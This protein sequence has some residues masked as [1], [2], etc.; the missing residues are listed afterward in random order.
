M[1]R[2]LDPKI[3]EYPREDGTTSYRVRVRTGGKQSTETFESRSAAAVFVERIKDP[4]VGPERAVALRSREDRASNDY[5]PTLTEML[6]RHIEG[7]TGVEGATKDEYQ[8]VARR[9]WLPMLGSLRVDELDD[10]DVARF[11]NALDGTMSPKTIKNAHGL[12]SSVMET[13]VRKQIVGHNPARGTRLP[14]AGEEDADEMRLLERDEFE[15]LYQETPQHYRP[16]VLTLFGTGLRWSEATALQVRDV[17]VSKSTLRVTRS[18]KR[19]TKPE[20]GFKIGPPKTKR[21]R[22][23]VA[24]P[25]E[26]VGALQPL[27]DRPGS[28]W[29]FTTTTGLVVRHNNFRN[30]IWLPACEAA[31]L[32]PRPKIH[33]ARHSQASWLLNAGVPI[34]VVQ[35]R[36]GHESIKTTVDTYGHLVPDLHIQAAA[37]A[38]AVFEGTN[39][40]ALPGG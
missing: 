30:R 35:A 32:E 22:R 13:A 23:T 29:L 39:L 18:W 17:S 34:H 27:L 5:V 19:Q 2:P 33:D 20:T 1:G 40:R 38:S 16:L 36:L 12:L 11:V 6:G 21:S 37:A 28:E 31:G 14:R 9:T 10:S 15:A 25:I 7:L 24:L 26:V 3:I 4:H 8:A